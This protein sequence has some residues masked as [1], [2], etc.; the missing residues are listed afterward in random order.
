[1]T[2]WDALRKA[3]DE[4]T[5][6]PWKARKYREYVV[7]ADAHEVAMVHRRADGRFIAR[8]RQAVPEML[9]LLDEARVALERRAPSLPPTVRVGHVDR[10]ADCRAV[11]AREYG[12]TDDRGLAEWCEDRTDHTAGCLWVKDRDLLARLPQPVE[13]E[14]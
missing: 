10:C 2:D 6:G 3:A 8:S 4:A 5:E 11:E 7:D 1:M 14:S 12:P 13:D 9:K